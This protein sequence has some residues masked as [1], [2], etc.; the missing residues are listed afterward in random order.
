MA[1]IDFNAP[2]LGNAAWPQ[3]FTVALCAVATAAGMLIRPA[4]AEDVMVECGSAA[5]LANP[6]QEAYDRLNA[7]IMHKQRE[8]VD[9]VRAEI[10]AIQPGLGQRGP[11]DPGLFAFPD[12]N[13]LPQ[14][15]FSLLNERRSDEAHALLSPAY[16]RKVARGDL[17][18]H[19]DDLLWRGRT[20]AA[21][22]SLR[23]LGTS[24]FDCR[25]GKLAIRDDIEL[26]LEEA[27]PVTVVV[28]S[29]KDGETWKIDAI[30]RAPR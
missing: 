24:G 17:A 8:L 13:G 2:F 7:C 22:S 23:Q 10:E 15:F 30:T 20:L 18:R 28:H 3:R 21:A 16:S 19:I 1:M 4:E 12:H 26:S 14:R 29:V 27:A 6:T 11:C 5:L 9:R 25:D